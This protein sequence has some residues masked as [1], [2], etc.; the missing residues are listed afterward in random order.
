MPDQTVLPQLYLLSDY[1]STDTGEASGYDDSLRSYF[2]DLDFGSPDRN[3]VL[4]RIEVVYESLREIPITV[5]VYRR[6]P[7][8]DTGTA[9]ESVSLT[10]AATQAQEPGVFWGT[11]SPVWATAS[12]ASSKIYSARA[13]FT[14]IQ[15]K[16]FSVGMAIDADLTPFRLLKVAFRYKVERAAQ[17]GDMV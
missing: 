13:D 12:Y 16:S 9:S 4:E 8:T 1:E 6:F 10:T 3:K 2:P 11:S 7:L 15:A 5:K 14:I 17:R